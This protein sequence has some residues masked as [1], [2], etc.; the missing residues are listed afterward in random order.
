MSED[1]EHLIP[2]GWVEFG[3]VYED[4]IMYAAYEF[5]EPELCNCHFVKINGKV[6]QF[7]E[8]PSDG[9]RSH[10]NV[11]VS[12]KEIPDY[13]FN[14]SKPIRVFLS[15]PDTSEFKK[16]D[17]WATKQWSGIVLS[18]SSN[19]EDYFA[20]FGTDNIDDYYPSIDIF[21]DAVKLTKAIFSHELEEI[22]NEPSEDSKV[23]S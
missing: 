6:F 15:K 5:S 11:T 3:G 14:L 17:D 20:Y 10:T 4:R 2:E 23:R 9:Y 8:D 21:F 18:S 7:T 1:A 13:K 22:C 12:D 16:D 19:A